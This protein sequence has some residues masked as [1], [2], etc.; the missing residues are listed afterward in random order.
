MKAKRILIAVLI[1]LALLTGVQV[2]LRLYG[3]RR[4]NEGAAVGQAVG[5]EVEAQ[6]QIKQMEKD[7][8]AAGLYRD[9]M[10]RSQR[11]NE[12]K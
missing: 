10:E 3:A 5:Q 12:G 8:N 9:L 4:F 11:I 7:K 6:K 1:A 2:A